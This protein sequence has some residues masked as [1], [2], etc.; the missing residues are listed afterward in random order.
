MVMGGLFD[1]AAGEHAADAA[2][3]RIP[4]AGEA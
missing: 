2:W 1:I 3:Y 4:L